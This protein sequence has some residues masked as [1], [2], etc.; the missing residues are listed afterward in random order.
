MIAFGKG[1]QKQVSDRI[2]VLRGVLPRGPYCLGGFCN[3]ALVAFAERLGTLH[4]A[5]LGA[6]RQLLL[7]TDETH[8]ESS[9]GLL[10]AC[11]KDAP[12]PGAEARLA[13]PAIR[14]AVRD[15]G[16]VLGLP[17]REVDTVAKRAKPYDRASEAAAEVARES[18]G[19][20]LAVAGQVGEPLGSAVRGAATSGFMDGFGVAMLA[21]QWGSVLQAGLSIASIVYGSLLGV[22]L[23]GLLTKRV[24]ERA[25]MTGMLAG[26]AMMLYVRFETHIAFTWWVLIGSAVTFLAGLLASFV[27]RENAKEN[28]LA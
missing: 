12:A 23:L 10:D 9:V 17:E 21:R 26:L 27:F 16:K 20:A 8:L 28:S 13:L 19:G 2:A 18:L 3:G 5:V 11:W 15:I 24:Q 7:V 4:A 14:S 6:T 22:F 25:A 1:A